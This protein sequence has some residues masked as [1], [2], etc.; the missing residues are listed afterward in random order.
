[1]ADVTYIVYG[2]TFVWDA[3]KA[4]DNIARHRGIGFRQA[5]GVFFD[6][7]IRIADASRN[8][9][10]RDKAIGYDANGE[11]LAVIHIQLQTE[12][13]RII[14]AWPATPAERAFYDS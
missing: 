13:I 12:A 6:P 11:L 14:S 2:A 9:E 3:I 8:L 1:M 10:S 4:R 5:T 7:F